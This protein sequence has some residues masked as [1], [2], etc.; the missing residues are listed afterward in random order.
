MITGD[1]C[2]YSKCDCETVSGID[3]VVAGMLPEGKVEA[4]RRL[5]ES[6]R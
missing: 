3:E 6:L 4:V 1:K 2:Q 5:K